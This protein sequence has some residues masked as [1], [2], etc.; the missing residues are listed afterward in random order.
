MVNRDWAPSRVIIN[1]RFLTQ[2]MSGVQRFAREL[3]LALDRLIGSDAIGSSCASRVQVVV[4]RDYVG[5][6][7]YSSLKLLR[8]GN[9]GG[10]LWE[11]A[12]LPWYARGDLLVNLCNAAPLFKQRQMVTVHDAA[13][14]EIPQAYGKLFGAWY[15]FMIPIVCQNAAARVTVSEFSR[16]ELTRILSL[17]EQSFAVVK[18][19]GEHILRVDSDRSILV[20][21]GLI[22]GRYVFAASNMSPSKNFSAVAQAISLLGDCGFDFAIAGGANPRVFA[23]GKVVLPSTV[24]HLGYV[25]DGELRALYENAGCFVYPSLYEGFGLPP[26]EAMHCG[27][28]VVASRAASLPEICG[29]AV[30]WCDP[31]APADIAQQIARIMADSSLRASMAMAG[32]K[33]AA[34]FSWQKSAIAFWQVIEEVYFANKKA[35]PKVN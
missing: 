25:S 19:S 27:C 35:E 31:L 11:Q 34:E 2:N 21:H 15:R 17:P 20:K 10:Q 16:R 3:L 9:L 30:I 5:D 12:F 18:E 33:R 8:V 23:S 26:L 14:W 24:K 22:P 13:V 32:A 29:N 1:G 7:E 28:P 4:P 6:N